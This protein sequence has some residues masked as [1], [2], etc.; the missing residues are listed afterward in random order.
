MAKAKKKQLPKDFE[1][2]LE[3]G[4]LDALKALFDA[5]DVNARG[6]VFKQTALA[7]NRCPDDLARWLVTRG[8]DLAAADRFGD[9]PLHS[10]AGHWQGRIEVLLELGAEVNLGE[11]QRGTPLHKAASVC[12]FP[13]AELLIRH[14]ARIDALNGEGQTPL[15]YTLQRCSN[16]KIEEVTAMAQV[17]IAAGARQ[18]PEMKSS[19]TRIGTDFEFHR[20]G[21]NPEYVDA[22]SAALDRLYVLFDVPPVPRRV[23]HDGKSPIVAR[24]ASWEDQHQELW[25]LLV[26]SSGA[27]STVQGEVVRIAGRVHDELERNGGVNWDNTYREMAD[28]FLVHVASGVP[29]PTA[30]LAE[31]R[32]I[33]AAV[34]RRDGD[35]RRL[36][37]LAVNWVALNP[38]PAKLPKPDYNR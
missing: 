21:F 17:L 12:N 4:D 31:A 10:R 27:A 8:A 6:G 1:A 29:L 14:G 7:F 26:P 9:T 35:A 24:S 28:A 32:E 38:T 33:V 20:D 19:V 5:H 13:A 11:N 16:A 22:T 3:K 37:E 18:T 25:E 23:Q 30:S 34:K 36:C 15:A 2:L